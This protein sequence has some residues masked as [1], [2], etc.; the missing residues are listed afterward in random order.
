MVCS[1]F[2][3]YMCIYVITG[4]VHIS[5]LVLASDT[6]ITEKNYFSLFFCEFLNKSRKF[7]Y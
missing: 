6:W 4:S 7:V 3:V 2:K 1:Y 5:V